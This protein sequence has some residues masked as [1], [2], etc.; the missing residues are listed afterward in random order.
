MC[1][2]IS[3]LR[4][5]QKLRTVNFADLY[6][7][8]QKPKAN[9]GAGLAP[10]TVGHVH[11]LMHQVLSHAVKWSLI[12]SNP[13]AAADPPRVERQEVEILAPDQVK[14]LLQGLRGHRLY[15]IAVL[16]LA[17]GMRRGELVALR[18]GDDRP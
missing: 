11:R 2:R 17:T 14:T 9:G 3:A 13:V 4:G 15:P 1:G 12:V 18:W 8:L 6:G 7:K 16:G 5:L 10:R